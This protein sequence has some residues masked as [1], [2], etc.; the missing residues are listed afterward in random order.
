MGK[1]NTILTNG[2]FIYLSNV[3]EA[4][5]TSCSIELFSGSAVSNSGS[6]PPWGGNIKAAPSSN[7]IVKFLIWTKMKARCCGVT[8]RSFSSAL[9][10]GSI[11]LSLMN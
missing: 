3:T 11:V 6:E 8:K 1:R 5:V 7:E 10:L 9:V 2:L 4:T